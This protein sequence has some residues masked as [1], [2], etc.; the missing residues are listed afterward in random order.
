MKTCS[1]FTFGCKV[2]QYETQLIRE[3]FLKQGYEETEQSPC[4]CVI[5][6]CTVTATADKKCRQLVKSLRKKNPKT[7]VVI[8]GCY[9]ENHPQGTGCDLIVP[10][11]DKHRIVTLLEDKLP[12]IKLSHLNLSV[13]D[14]AKHN[15]AFVKIEDGC[16]NFCTYCIVPLMRGAPV[17]KKQSIITREIKDLIKKGFNEIILTGVDLG[18]WGDDL[19]PRSNIAELLMEIE[20]IPGLGRIRLS[21]I[22][23]KYLTKPVIEKI[24]SSNKICNHL[25]IPLQSGDDHILKIMNRKYSS[26]EYM[27]KIKEIKNMC[28]GISFTTDIIVGFPGES[29]THFNNTLKVVKE[30]GFSR[31][32]VFS[33]SPREKTKAAEFSGRIDKKII[34]ERK[35]KLQKL[36][37]QSS[38]EFRE[39]LLNK[40]VSVLF[41]RKE[42]DYWR[43]YSDSYVEV[44]TKAKDNLENLILPVKVIKVNREETLGELL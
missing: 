6:G 14:F 2:N 34:R 31:I 3:Q 36:A 25:H 7:Y 22:E 24:I 42:N 11:K 4:V 17:S 15:R 1:F 37:M 39:K 38:H 5:N 44:K 26:A 12:K 19:S 30:V 43:G 9:V 18:A 23:L 8:T 20:L 10:Q 32:H 29:D 27:R 16:S 13:H 41:E 21:S 40:T 33:Y 35:D 28:P